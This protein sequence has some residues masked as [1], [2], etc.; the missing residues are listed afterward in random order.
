MKGCLALYILG[1]ALPSRCIE[2]G[3]DEN[4]LTKGLDR[5]YRPC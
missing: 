2:E 3:V 4:I 5:I 1:L